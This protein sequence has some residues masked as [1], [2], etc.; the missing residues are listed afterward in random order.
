MENPEPK[1]FELPIEWNFGDLLNRY[2]TNMLIQRGENEFYISF[3]EITPPLLFSP[4]DHGKIKSVKANCVA[5]IVIAKD[6][7]QSFIDALQQ[8]VVDTNNAETSED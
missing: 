2:A 4:A 5:R 3:F 1:E 7:L 8:S 6:K